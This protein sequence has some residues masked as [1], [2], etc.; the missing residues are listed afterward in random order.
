MNKLNWC[1]AI[2][3]CQQAGRGYVIAT[4]IS[5][6]GSTP[7]DGG[8][9]MVIDPD[10]C[11]DTLGGGQLEFLVI[12]HARELLAENKTCPVMRPI[13]LA[14]EAAQCCG[15][16]VVVMLECFASVSWQINVF[17]AGHV[18]Q[19]LVT[20]L[21]GLPCQVRLID[22]RVE[23]QQLTLPPNVE[24]IHANDPVEV[25]Q[26]LPEASWN[27]I[28]THDHQL[29]YRLCLALLE[30]GKWAFSGLIGSR[31]KAQR[32]R[33]RMQ[34]DGYDDSAIT[35]PIGLADVRG[36][37]PME[38][39]VSITAQLQSLYY[40]D[41]PKRQASHNPWR[42]IKRMLNEPSVETE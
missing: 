31:T 9:K 7:R 38:V 11:Y 25:V 4:L 34:S 26:H 21:A 16:N 42:D 22:S 35:C 8:S 13:P 12:Q 40:S 39:A 1:Q 28:I 10:H 29:D 2:Q 30:Q 20:I 37:L 18:G 14:A 32:F 33:R 23:Y 41:Q 5:T 36:K 19:A 15:G 27:V 6:Q 3:H 24:L 17:G